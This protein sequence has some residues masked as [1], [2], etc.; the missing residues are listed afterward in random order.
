MP[1]ALLNIILA[2]AVV[3]AAHWIGWFYWNLSIDFDKPLW[4]VASTGL[5]GGIVALLPKANR[6]WIKA[7]FGPVIHSPKTTYYLIGYLAVTCCVAVAFS[8]TN[9]R[10]PV[11]TENVLVNGASIKGSSARGA[12]EVEVFRPAFSTVDAQVSDLHKTARATPFLPTTIIFTESEVNTHLPLYKEVQSDLLLTYYQYFES[13]FL[14]QANSIFSTPGAQHFQ[15]LNEIYPILRRCFVDVDLNNQNDLSIQTY[16]AEHPHSGWTPLLKSCTSYSR[17]QYDKAIQEVEDI[18]SGISSQFVTTYQ[19]FRGVNRLKLYAIKVVG[20]DPS[21][22]TLGQMAVQDFDLA[23]KTATGHGVFFDIARQSSQIFKGISNVYL[24]LFDT[25]LESFVLASNGPYPGLR[26]RAYNDIGYVRIIQGNLQLAA[27]AFNQALQIQGT[28]PTARVNL[29]YVEMALGNYTGA[30]SILTSAVNDPV[31]QQQSP[32]DILLAK[33]GLAHLSIRTGPPDPDAYN[34]VMNSKRL[35]KFEGE[36]NPLV[37]LA[38]IHRSL[39]TNL[40]TGTDYY[41]LEVFAMA[42][43]AYAYFE[44]DFAFAQTPSQGIATI[45]ENA[46]KDFTRLRALVNPGWF[47]N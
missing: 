42:M 5:V 34:D 1:T 10:F 39:A 27:T 28:F 47:T 26:S 43:D 46:L 25:A 11:G 13:N 24:S 4:E 31:V 6:E 37:R 12:A 23:S 14:T 16:S 40:Y 7:K 2:V 9:I 41:G 45:K 15:Q 32:R 20:S 33:A 8:K 36:S 18:P 44:A 35:Y 38:E 3:L 30:R 19:F 29:A 22:Q 17:R 21:A